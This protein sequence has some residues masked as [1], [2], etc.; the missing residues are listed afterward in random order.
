[1]GVAVEPL[2]GLP[3]EGAIRTTDFAPQG[4]VRGTGSVVMLDHAENGTFLGTSFLLDRVE[5]VAWAA[6]GTVVLDSAYAGG[7]SARALNFARQFNLRATLVESARPA[8]EL[9]R[10]RLGLAARD[11]WVARLFERYSVPYTSATGGGW[12]E[13]FDTVVIGTGEDIELSNQFVLGGGT[14]V[15]LPSVMGGE[16]TRA[17]FE[18]SEPVA[19]G[20][21]RVEWVRSATETLSRGRVIARFEQ[22]GQAAIAEEA[23]GK[24]RV[25]S[26][27][28][29]PDTYATCRLLLNAVYLGSARRL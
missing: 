27:A 23:S 24:G 16:F 7:S 25:I 15:R 1:M 26:F 13:K 20:M 12:R 11:A 5:G 18:L 19:F 21:P 8:Y 22:S 28:F 14:V 29:Q 4:S 3:P 9:K 17:T 2:A 6:D 10:P